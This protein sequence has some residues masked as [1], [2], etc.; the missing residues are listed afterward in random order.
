MDQKGHK[1]GQTGL[2]YMKYIY[3]KGVFGLKYLLFAQFCWRK[4]CIWKN[5]DTF[6]IIRKIGCHLEKSGQF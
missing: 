3:E 5:P 1:M 2:R 6:E 4:V